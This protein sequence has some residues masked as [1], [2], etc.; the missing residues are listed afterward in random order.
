M[1]FRIKLI[2]QIIFDFDGN[3]VNPILTL[4]QSVFPYRTRR[5]H[6]LIILFCSQDTVGLRKEGRGTWVSW[7]PLRP[8][9]CPSF[10]PLEA[11][12][13][14]K[15]WGCNPH[16]RPAPVWG[17]GPDPCLPGGQFSSRWTATAA[18]L[19]VGWLSLSSRM[20]TSRSAV[21]LSSPMSSAS[22]SSSRTGGEKA[23]RSM[24]IPDL[25][26]TTP[27]T[28]TTGQGDTKDQRCDGETRQEP[29]QGGQKKVRRDGDRDERGAEKATQWLSSSKVQRPMFREVP[30]PGVLGH[31]P[32]FCLRWVPQ[33]GGL[34]SSAERGASTSLL[35]SCHQIGRAQTD[36]T[37]EFWVWFE[38]GLLP[39]EDYGPHPPAGR[40]QE[41][42]GFGG[43]STE[44]EFMSQ[45]VTS[46][47]PK[48]LPGSSSL[49][50]GWPNPAVR[51]GL[52]GTGSL[53]RAW[54]Q[55]WERRP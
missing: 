39:L 18:G 30:S 17:L 14:S 44:A 11:T 7:P 23:S 55:H 45:Q 22:S 37:Q 4:K 35:V 19:K 25:T 36:A 42:V 52:W 6:I 43:L 12:S 21:P 47:D 31:S 50:P 10:S 28:S 5:E 3:H 34:S 32:E 20:V 13:A 49:A 54:T 48:P 8:P 16:T 27:G 24:T 29:T 9:C 46:V 41:G 26:V 40:R 1:F 53:W 2:S 38:G 33:A 51:W 15:L